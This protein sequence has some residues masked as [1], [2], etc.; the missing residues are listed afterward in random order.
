LVVAFFVLAA[1]MHLLHLRIVPVERPAAL[2]ES[3]ESQAEGIGKEGSSL[4][5]EH[6]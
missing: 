1:A 4:R 6:W 2:I 5:T 3:Q